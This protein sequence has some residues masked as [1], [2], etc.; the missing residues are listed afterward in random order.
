[1]TALDLLAAA[2]RAKVGV[3]GSMVPP[4]AILWPDASQ[5][6]RRLLPAARSR[7]PEL[8]VLGDYRP[9][10]RTGPAIWLRCVIDGTIELPDVT[11]D[12]PPVVYLPGI[13]R[14]QLRAGE[15]CP[16][17]LRPL[18]ELLYRGVP[19]HHPNG[20]DW[21]VRA[22][23][24][25]R[26]AGVP[27]GP[28]LD[29]AGD[30]ETREALLRAI[31]E[32]AQ[33]PLD[34]L[35]GRR[36]D[37]NAFNQIAGVEIERDILRWMGDPAASRKTMGDARW[38]AFRD[39]ARNVLKFDPE[40]GSDVEAG[41]KLAQGKGRWRAV[42][43]RFR[44]APK[45]FQGVAEVLRR[46]RPQGE[47]VLEGRDRW[48]DLNDE[49]EMSVRAALGGLPGLSHPDACAEI[50]RLEA[51]HGQRREWVWAKMEEAPLAEML[52]PLARL[53]EAVGKSVGG[54][55]PDDIARVYDE[56]GWQADRSAREALALAR[57]QHE[58]LIADAVRHLTKP[59]LNQSAQ[60][61]Q[62]AV[63]DHPLP[64]VRTGSVKEPPS[65]A[66]TA[67]HPTVAAAPMSPVAA[68]EQECLLFVDG[69]RYELG[70]CLV[71]RLRER[72][73]TA[74]IRSRWAAIPT[75][76]ATAKPAVTPVA[77]RIAGDR[78]GAD[79]Q[80][81]VRG[82]GRPASAGT[83]REAMRERGYEIVR[84]D[85]L[86]LGPPPAA[87]GWRETGRIDHHGH[88]HEAAG[89]ARLVEDE[90]DRLVRRVLELIE[91]GWTSVRIVTDHG[92][93]LLPGGLPMVTLPG[94]LTESKWARAAVLAGEARPDA[95]LHPWHWNPDECFASPPGIACFSKRP[96]Y[97]HGGLSVQ[98]CL[99]PDIRISAKAADGGMAHVG[100]P[101]TVI[102]SVSWLR[103]RCNVMVDSPGAGATADLRLGSSSGKSV[104]SSPKAIDT[105]GC[106]SLILRDE[107]HEDA[108]L[109]LVVIASDG[110]VLAH[111]TTRRGDPPA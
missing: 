58:E 101:R 7:I 61:F 39:Q 45:S 33:T 98:E 14:G 44:E 5:D 63:R 52:R 81:V 64:S 53:A 89:F 77:D 28:G 69:L 49:D 106:A 83:L 2:I 108:A 47:L 4:A 36:L 1:M 82:S 93:L 59:W 50:E 40:A 51:E 16:E 54:A 78:L 66:Y 62:A 95:P 102:R 71:E 35:R 15:D 8:L 23:L 38:D 86:D 24:T 85:A 55:A 37:A 41:A 79:F 13:E 65:T 25:L 104:A 109:V 29:I 73:L 21:S 103:M 60:A 111:R 68:T 30:S 87:R 32:V 34:E 94:H 92:W 88:H 70:R 84:D 48:P 11:G 99:I 57:P 12:G 43:S 90:L 74:A 67:T 46:S 6:W 105:D 76:T 20:R 17:H 10:D 19:W 22:F 26:A 75:V 107:D 3:S 96:E 27:A 100:L 31:G 18:V 91:A 9:D 97:A 80:P 110:R 56:R 42:W 72:G